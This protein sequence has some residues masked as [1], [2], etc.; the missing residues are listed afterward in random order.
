MK[1]QFKLILDTNRCLQ[2]PLQPQT[3]KWTLNVQYV[4]EKFAGSKFIF[5]YILMF[6]SR[7]PLVS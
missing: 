6:N 4:N 1:G 5:A 7:T 3:R 2:Q